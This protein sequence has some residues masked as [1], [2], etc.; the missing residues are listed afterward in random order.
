MNILA[1]FG[2][3]DEYR[4][5]LANPN[6]LAGQTGGTA[7]TTYIALATFVRGLPAFRLTSIPSYSL[8]MQPGGTLA[9]RLVLSLPG[10]EVVGGSGE[11]VYVG[12]A[13]LPPVFSAMATSGS[14]SAV[15]IHTHHLL[16]RQF[17]GKF[18]QA[19]LDIEDYTVE[20][21]RD[22]HEGI[23]GKGGGDAWINSWN[24]QWKRFFDRNR[25]PSRD[26][27]LQQLEAMKQEF[28]IP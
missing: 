24:Q 5:A 1:A 15:P 19:G 13:G 2:L 12:V 4:A 23:H 21:P 25:N 16:P 10:V 7:G 3:D 6:F 28:G 27:I 9:L 17:R 22:F 18:E 14:S 11:L 20:L 26:L 8:E